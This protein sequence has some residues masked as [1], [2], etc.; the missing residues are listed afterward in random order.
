MP[1]AESRVPLGAPEELTP[2]VFQPMDMPLAEVILREV[3]GVLDDFGIVFFLRHGTCLGAVRDGA[4]IPWD[5]DLDIASIIGL[6]GLTEDQIK[7]VADAFIAHGFETEVTTADLHVS[8]ELHRDGIGLDWTCYRI[9]DD[10][11][12]QWPVLKIPVSLH[13]NLKTI[14]FLKEQFNVPNPPEEYLSL[15]Y[16]PDW[17]TPKQFGYEKDVLGLMPDQEESDAQLVK[18][19][20]VEPGILK[21]LGFDG[22]PVAGATVVLGST[23]ML[24]GLVRSST[25]ADGTTPLNLPNS[26]YYV[27]EIAFDDHEEIL[28]LEKLEVSTEYVYRPDPEVPAGRMNVLATYKAAATGKTEVTEL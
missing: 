26:G 24:T 19:S 28:F 14:P 16:G 13:T 15:K 3:K 8:L 7:P 22:Q 9:I 4:L 20:G 2:S 25:S 17:E 21:V 6:H 27:M 12:Y 5:D 10:S 23:T 11:I 1:E 18:A